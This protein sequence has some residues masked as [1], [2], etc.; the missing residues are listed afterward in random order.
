MR[1]IRVT[2]KF[3]SDPL[4]SALI[5]AH[6]SPGHEVKD[7]AGKLGW[8]LFFP[9]PFSL[10]PVVSLDFLSSVGLDCRL[11]VP[12]KSSV[13]V[14]FQCWREIIAHFRCRS[15]WCVHTIEAII[16]L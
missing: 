9:F 8:L 1:L 7:F 16:I 6:W 11:V 12:S 3:L 15:P 2:G 4:L 14:F 10:F 13:W 5:C